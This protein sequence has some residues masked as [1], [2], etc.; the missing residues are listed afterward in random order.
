MCPPPLEDGQSAL[1]LQ[2]QCAGRLQIKLG[3]G[4]TRS[5]LIHPFAVTLSSGVSISRRFYLAAMGAFVY[6]TLRLPGNCDLAARSAYAAARESIGKTK[7][8]VRKS[9]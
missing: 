7:W 3:E 1:R 8:L 4:W 6:H 5:T 9:G 2:R